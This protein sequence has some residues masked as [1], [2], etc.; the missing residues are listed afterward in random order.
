MLYAQDVEAELAAFQRAVEAEVS[1]AAAAEEADSVKAEADK[2][3]YEAHEQ[4]WVG[5]EC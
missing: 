4:R 3:D 2:E 1:V 5:G